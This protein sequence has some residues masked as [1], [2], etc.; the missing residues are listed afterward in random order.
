MN[1]MAKRRARDAKKKIA[2]KQRLRI[3]PKRYK[4]P[5]SILKQVV[6]EAEELSIHQDQGGK[7]PTSWGIR[8]RSFASGS[9]WCKKSRCRSLEKVE[10]GGSNAI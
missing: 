8:A 10:A 5:V 3:C 2:P 4:V 6:E 1:K 7:T 9:R